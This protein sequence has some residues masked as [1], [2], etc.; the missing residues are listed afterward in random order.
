MDLKIT[1]MI[2][3]QTHGSG[4]WYVRE[5]KDETGDGIKPVFFRRDKTDLLGRLIDKFRGVESAQRYAAAHFNELGFKVHAEI[6]D[7]LDD[8]GM[9]KKP[10]KKTEKLE[11][12]HL[13]SLIDGKCSLTS[14]K[15]PKESMQQ[16]SDQDLSITVVIK[17]DEKKIQG[18]VDQLWSHFRMAGKSESRGGYEEDTFKRLM[19]LSLQL[20]SGLARADAKSWGVCYDFIYDLAIKYKGVA[21]NE[22]VQS[23]LYSLKNFFLFK[24]ISISTT[25][26]TSGSPIVTPEVTDLNMNQLWNEIS[27]R[28]SKENQDL[29]REHLTQ[30]FKIHDAVSV[31]LLTRSQP[32]TISGSKHTDI[33]NT[34]YESLKLPLK[35]AA[36]QSIN[37]L[38]DSALRYGRSKNKTPGP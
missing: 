33:L 13:Q 6:S 32:E 29:T 26:L 1:G 27:L 28:I 5:T 30:A 31:A 37:V 25:L 12:D 20:E 15:R 38:V 9:L 8:S 18:E 17:S 10:E 35:P 23:L 22:Q 11:A 34:L 36:S 7:V 2:I 24:D 4:K 21:G 16:D 3:D 19:Q 14:S